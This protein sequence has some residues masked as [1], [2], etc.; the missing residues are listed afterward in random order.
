MTE[1]AFAKWTTM[2]TG[3]RFETTEAIRKEETFVSSA[4][5][6]SVWSS[7]HNPSAFRAP[8]VALSALPRIGRSLTE[9]E[10]RPAGTGMT[11]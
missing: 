5:V 8:L 2:S 7:L 11:S 4:T 6:I 1:V 3:K 10:R 9:Q